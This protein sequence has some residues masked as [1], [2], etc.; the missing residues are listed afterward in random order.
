[1]TSFATVLFA[2]SLAGIVYVYAGYPALV[3]LLAHLYP[4]PVLRRPITPRVSVIVAAYNEETAIEAK[5]HDTLG[6]GYPRA[7]LEIVVASDGSTDATEVRAHAVG[8]PEVTVMRLPRR[9]KL[10]ALEAGVAAATGEILVFTDADVLLAPGSIERLVE[11]FADPEVGGVAGQKQVRARE[12]ATG[13]A[14][15]EGL[16]A[17][18]DEW[19][20]S[21]ESRFGSAVASHGALHAVRRELFAR[22]GDPSGAD[23]MS[24]SM[25][26]VLQGHRLVLDPRAVALVHPPSD[27]G[28]EL[29]RK[30]RIANQVIRALLDLGPALWTSGFYSVQ[31]VSHKLLRYMV[32]FFLALV[33]VS[34]AILAFQGGFPWREVLAVQIAFYALAALGALLQG[35]SAGRRR[36]LSIPYYFCLVNAAAA[37][38]VLAVLRGERM[39]LWHPGA[40]SQPEASS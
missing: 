28:T 26:V 24:I 15:G 33:L 10:A 37:L 36:A 31:L 21:M 17:R 32:P 6:N 23:D 19:Q 3:A 7:R 35:R 34:S 9:G 8:A 30:V 22:G 16:Y 13:V 5:I 1:M 11:N 29:R 38:S 4:R 39:A 20:K 14:R 2:A 27:A 25:R 12:G 40:G 18:F